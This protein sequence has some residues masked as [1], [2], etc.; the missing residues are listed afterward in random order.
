M[1]KLSEPE[2]GVCVACKTAN[3]LL[4]HNLG[5]GL[6]F[7]VCRECKEDGTYLTWL[8]RELEA[9]ADEAGWPF[10]VDERGRKLYTPPGSTPITL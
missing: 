6:E 5:E 2:P 1:S 8:T 4:V 3:D 10:I 7:S 9:A